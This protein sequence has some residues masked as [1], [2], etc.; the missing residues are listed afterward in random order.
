MDV[1]G[2]FYQLW[3]AVRYVH[4][5]AGAVLI[6]GAALLSIVVAIDTSPLSNHAI[7]AAAVA[8][9][10]LFWV[11]AAVSVA[12]GI[13]N[14]GLKGDGLLPA[15]TQWGAA[16]SVKLSAALGLLAIA[17]LRTEAVV[18]LA[19]LGDDIANGVQRRLAWLYGATVA[20]LLAILWLGLGLAHGRY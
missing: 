9:E 13:S 18:C 4:L 16:L 1:P 7:A 6:G 3:F 19:M 8:Y 17:M 20:A 10:W 12:T 14:L 11:V 15:D 2:G 5:A